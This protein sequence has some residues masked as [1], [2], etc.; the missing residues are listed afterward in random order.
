MTRHVLSLT[1]CAS[2]TQEDRQDRVQWP[3]NRINS[4]SSTE[5]TN[6]HDKEKHAVP[7][8][9]SLGVCTHETVV[10]VLAV[11]RLA[12]D[13]TAEALCDLMA[14]VQ[15]RVGDRRGVQREEGDVDHEVAGAEVR[16]GVRLVRGLVEQTLRREDTRYV[17]LGR[18]LQ[19]PKD[20]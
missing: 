14:V 20:V 10:D 1:W 4:T 19:N 7:P 17:V 2:G 16:G 12:G 8:F 15:E 11:V 13:K 9:R 18:W 3:E 6:T 5:G